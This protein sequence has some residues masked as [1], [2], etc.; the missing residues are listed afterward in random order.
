MGGRKK[1]FRVNPT[2]GAPLRR[3]PWRRLPSL[4]RRRVARAF[5][6]WGVAAACAIAATM[7]V[8]CLAF[9]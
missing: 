1:L 8:A 2:I 6:V 7:Y 9:G 5:V 4:M 3:P